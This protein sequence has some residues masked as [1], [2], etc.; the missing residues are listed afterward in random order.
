MIFEFQDHQVTHLEWVSLHV[1]ESGV[2]LELQRE[3]APPIRRLPLNQIYFGEASRVCRLAGTVD[4]VLTDEWGQAVAVP[5]WVCWI[6]GW[7]YPALIA[8]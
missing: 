8:P 6:P 1:A 3:L 5:L 7:P 2:E 4:D